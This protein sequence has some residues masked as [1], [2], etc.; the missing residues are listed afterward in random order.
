MKQQQF[1]NI[2]KNYESYQ[3]QFQIQNR[4]ETETETVKTKPNL[5]P[6]PIPKSKLIHKATYIRVLIGENDTVNVHKDR[7]TNL[8][9]VFGSNLAVRKKHIA[10]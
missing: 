4:S 3:F 2:T 8:Q 1:R 6:I 9:G 7:H 10:K 5:K